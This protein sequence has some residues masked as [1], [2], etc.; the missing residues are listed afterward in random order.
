M[1]EKGSTASLQ[2]RNEDGKPDE[3]PGTRAGLTETRRCAMVKSNKIKCSEEESRF[4][5][6]FTESVLPQKVC[7]WLRGT[8]LR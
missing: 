5:E 2:Q 8:G 4:T 3:K 6:C 7:G 1:T